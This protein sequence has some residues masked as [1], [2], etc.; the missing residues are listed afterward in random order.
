MNVEC[1]SCSTS[2][3]VDPKKVPAGGVNARC[4]ICDG[5]FFVEDPAPV[6]EPAFEAT[7]LGDEP[8]EAGTF[9]APEPAE[10]ETFETP[11]PAEAETFETGETGEVTFSFDEPE[12]RFGGA[13]SNFD[14]DT[15]SLN[16]PLE[17]PPED[18]P[19][20][21]PLQD[22]VSTADQPEAIVDSG[23]IL[24]QL[25]TP[26]FGKRDPKE[27][28]QRLARVLVS[29]IILYNPDRHQKALNEDRIK[30]EFDDEIQKSLSEYIEQ[31][32]EEIAN[33]NNFL[34]E[35]LNEILAKGQQLF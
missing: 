26:T 23:P 4:S 9:E 7:A 21:P 25:P 14:L 29:D 28:A 5:V 2:F 18:K 13:E 31:V 1:P 30:E 35:A 32:G 15:P 19:P 8:A 27:K 10:A 11:E 3:P 6:A 16:E 33:E 34:N 12:S 17:T 24:T 22:E 20:E